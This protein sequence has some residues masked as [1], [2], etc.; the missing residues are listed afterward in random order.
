VDVEHGFANLVG[1]GLEWSGWAKTHVREVMLFYLNPSIG[2]W[3]FV[4]SSGSFI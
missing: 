2:I 1:L 4:L 3:D